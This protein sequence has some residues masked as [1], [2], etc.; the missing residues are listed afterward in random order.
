MSS[1]QYYL[2][3][4]LVLARRGGL[5]TQPNPRVGAI[6]VKNGKIVGAGFHEKC[7]EA[8]AEVNALKTAAAAGKDAEKGATLFV[9]LEPCHHQG[10]TPPCTAAILTSGIKEVYYCTKDTN[11]KVSGSGAE[12][13]QSQGLLV[14]QV[15]LGELDQRFLSSWLFKQRHNRAKILGIVCLSINGELLNP[16]SLLSKAVYQRRFERFKGQF[17]LLISKQEELTQSVLKNHEQALCHCPSLIMRLREVSLL[18]E[19]LVIHAPLLSPLAS[20]ESL[21][22]RDLKLPALKLLSAKRFREL[23]LAHYQL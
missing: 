6:V 18:D 15:S 11:P 4:A 23:S 7:G 13:L 14:E 19:L 3:R 12:F 5:K 9:S 16:K 21:Q 17:D 1:Q 2:K 10:K 8:H 22:L 20:K